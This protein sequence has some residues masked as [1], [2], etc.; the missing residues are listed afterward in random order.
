MK[1]TEMLL[2]GMVLWTLVGVLGTLLR[3]AQGDRGRARRGLRWIA[4]VW[5]VYLGV[6]LL[7]SLGEGQREMAAGAKQ[8][9]DE[10][11]FA[12]EGADEVEGFFVREQER[13][14][15]V[16]V[17]VRVTNRGRGRP[18]GEGLIRAYLVDGEG[19][20]W[21]EV[22]GL[23]GVR[24][25]SRLAAGDSAVSEPVFRVAKD[26]TRL[27][28][29]LTHGKWQPGVLVIG[30]PDSW[31]HRPTVMRLGAV[32][33]E[34]VSTGAKTRVRRHR[35]EDTEGVS[36]EASIEARGGRASPPRGGSKEIKR[37]EWGR[38]L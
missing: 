25:T 22:R 38:S 30:D 7:V 31:R 16:R 27:G 23:S 3:W 14:R 24:L 1:L 5:A 11:C 19:R 26:A 9:F 13:E 2:F 6:L 28:L 10:M 21:D 12:V 4:G 8:C 36:R 15:L 29:V 17:H 33:G 35:C 37:R 18:Q 20:R 32:K 34:E